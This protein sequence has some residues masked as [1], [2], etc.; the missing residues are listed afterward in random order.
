MKNTFCKV[1]NF[2]TGQLLARKIKNDDYSFPILLETYKEGV[3]LHY[4]IGFETDSNAT[5]AINDLTE[6]KAEE[7]FNQLQKMK[8]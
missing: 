6:E 2:S 5:E 1:F 4:R 7:F 8:V 3:F